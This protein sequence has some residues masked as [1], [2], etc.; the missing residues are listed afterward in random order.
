MFVMQRTC[1]RAAALTALLFVAAVAPAWCQEP[2]L[3]FEDDFSVL[4]ASLGEADDT[5]S[6]EDG[7]LV[8]KL[9]ENMWWRS[10]YQS[11]VF[12]DIDL[13][14]KVQMPDLMAEQGGGIGVMFWGTSA[15][16]MYVLEISDSGTFA[17]RRFTPTRILYPVMWRS[18]D[19][20]NVEP[21]EWNELRVVTQGNVATIYIN[22][23]EQVRLKG[24]PPAGGSFVGLFFET[25]ES[26]ADEGR[27]TALKVVAPPPGDAA[28]AGD[29]SALFSDDFTTLDPGWGSATDALK[30]VDGK[31]VI[32]P[33]VDKAWTKFYE[34][35]VVDGDFEAS[36]KLHVNRMNDQEYP[37]GALAFWGTGLDDYWAYYLLPD[38]TIGVIHW[39]KDKW[40]FPMK[41]KAIPAEAKFDPNGMTELKV[42]AQGRRLTFF[43]NG[44]NVGSM[45]GM[46]PKGGGYVGMYNESAKSG[47]SVEYDDFVVKR[48]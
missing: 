44:V 35:D 26:A 15:D 13:T 5:Q 40:L 20:I 43:V 12:E 19:A 25:G 1:G 30:V 42:V 31:L 39:M 10:F 6:V 2:E 46:P 9:T 37:M 11:M 4:D 16:D 29:P 32:T 48:N 24:R 8:K 38:G 23:K 27:F 21:E 17:V 36:L 18:S 7:A 47:G 14:I 34:A 45:S 3:L 41:G 22:G 28:V 33:T